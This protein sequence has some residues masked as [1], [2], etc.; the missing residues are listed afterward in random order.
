MP[1]F[2]VTTKSN[3]STNE[4]NAFPA[5]HAASIAARYSEG[6][7][8][9][10]SFRS[11]QATSESICTIPNCPNRATTRC[12]A[13]QPMR[14]M[15]LLARFKFREATSLYGL[16]DRNLLAE[17]AGAGLALNIYDST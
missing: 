3:G 17:S 13:V 8:F 4:K 16:S 15:I 5:I 12:N 2:A 1:S 7:L 11:E 9:Q 14:Q 6:D 10:I